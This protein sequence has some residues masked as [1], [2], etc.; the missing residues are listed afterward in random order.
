MQTPNALYNFLQFHMHT[1][2][3]H[4]LDGQALDGEMHFVHRSTNDGALLVV[5]LFFT[6]SEGATTDPFFADVLN[7]MDSTDESTPTDLTL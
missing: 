1:P 3:E 2:S 5:G 4:T 7:A 6:A